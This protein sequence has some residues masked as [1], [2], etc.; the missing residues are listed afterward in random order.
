M[1]TVDTP[2]P[3]SDWLGASFSALVDRAK[4]TWLDLP[5]SA[6]FLS[7]GAESAC[8]IIHD[9]VGPTGPPVRPDAGELFIVDDRRISNWRDDGFEYE[10]RENTAARSGGAAA[11]IAYSD[12]TVYGART[13]DR[14]TLQHAAG[15]SIT[16]TFFAGGGTGGGDDE[17]EEQTLVIEWAL[18]VDGGAQ[19]RAL[20]LPRSGVGADGH[21]WLVQYLFDDAPPLYTPEGGPAG[22]AG[23]AD[24]LAA[25]DEGV[26]GADV[27]AEADTAND[28]VHVSFSTGDWTD[29]AAAS[30]DLGG[31]DGGENASIEESE[32]L[33]ALR[34]I[35]ETLDARSATSPPR[36]PAR[37]AQLTRTA[38]PI[39]ML[40]AASTLAAN[41]AAAARVAAASAASSPT[42]FTRSPESLREAADA[43]AAARR[44]AEAAAAL[45][46]RTLTSRRAA[47]L[48]MQSRRIALAS[49]LSADT[50]VASVSSASSSRPIESAAV[51]ERVIADV[52]VGGLQLPSTPSAPVD[53]PVPMPP[54]APAA[55]PHVVHTAPPISAASTVSSRPPLAPPQRNT[56]SEVGAAAARSASGSALPAPVRRSSIGSGRNANGDDDGRRIH[57]RRSGGRHSDGVRGDPPRR[58]R[59]RRDEPTAVRRAARRHGNRYSEISA[60]DDDVSDYTT[61]DSADGDFEYVGSRR[62]ASSGAYT[63][64]YSEEISEREGGG[65]R[66]GGG[67]E[68]KSGGG[69]RH[70]D[71]RSRRHHRSAHDRRSREHHAS[72]V[73]GPRSGAVSRQSSDLHESY[74]WGPPPAPAQSTWASSSLQAEAD[75]LLRSLV[76]APTAF[77][78][79]AS[80]ASLYSIPPASAPPA[81]VATAFGRPASASSLSS[82]AGAGSD[83]VGIGG[84]LVRALPLQQQQQPPPPPPSHMTSAHTAD[85]LAAIRALEME[86]ED[87]I[88]ADETAEIATANAAMFS[89]AP[90]EVAVSEMEEERISTV[91]ASVP[92]AAPLTLPLPPEIDEKLGAL[93]KG[94]R[95][96]ALLF[97]VPR[98]VGLCARVRD[99][100]SA[101]AGASGGVDDDAFTASLAAQLRAAKAEL[102]GALGLRGS[103]G[104]AGGGGLAELLRFLSTAS[105]ARARKGGN[106]ARA[107]LLPPR[108]RQG[109]K[110]VP[111]ARGLARAAARHASLKGGSLG[112][113]VADAAR[114]AA[115][116]LALASAQATSTSGVGS[117]S[118]AIGVS[119]AASLPSVSFSA[120][121]VVSAP[122]PTTTAA[123]SPPRPR[124]TTTSGTAAT[125]AGSTGLNENGDGVED[126]VFPGERDDADSAPQLLD[127]AASDAAAES[128]LAALE[129]SGSFRVFAFVSAARSL[130]PG[131]FVAATAA[132]TTATS[133]TRAAGAPHAA[134][135][136]DSY[137]SAFVTHR[138]SRDGARKVVGARVSSGVSARTLAP[139]YDT[140]MLLP[141]PPLAG[142][143]TRLAMADMALDATAAAAL[144]PSW[145]AGNVGGL[146][147]AAGGAGW[148]AVV[149]VLDADRFAKETFLGEL[150]LPLAIL[151]VITLGG[152]PG[153]RGALPPAEWRTLSFPPGHAF[154]GSRAALRI[155]VA[156]VAPDHATRC[157][158]I[159]RIL[160]SPPT[161]AA[162][163]AASAP[164]LVRP[165]GAKP[166]ASAPPSVTAVTPAPTP[167]SPP[168]P[169][170]TSLRGGAE[171]GGVP[172]T[173]LGAGGAPAR[174]ASAMTRAPPQR[175]PP[176]VPSPTP[177]PS[178]A[179]HTPPFPAI[180]ASDGRAGTRIPVPARVVGAATS[181]ATSALAR[182]TNAPAAPQPSSV[183]AVPSSIR[184]PSRYPA[185]SAPLSLSPAS[186]AEVDASILRFFGAQVGQQPQLPAQTNWPRSSLASAVPAPAPASTTMQ[187]P[188][189][190]A[191]AEAAAALQRFESR[192]LRAGRSS[193]VG[194]GTAATTTAQPPAESTGA[195]GKYVDA[196]R[197]AQEQADAAMA[198]LDALRL[199]RPT[200]AQY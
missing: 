113:G 4:E 101:L 131:A 79:F 158:T 155:R 15:E 143:P 21:I 134:P 77:D 125:L 6:E 29:V 76:M 150:V 170:S 149:T 58:H 185:P 55:V 70:H 196:A 163:A 92:L 14:D 110:T 138:A 144:A 91:A 157:T 18:A 189:A 156:L 73:E 103:G 74:I 179:S 123:F 136:R 2:D 105:A 86:E 40:A 89:V 129:A 146:G 10:T 181:A 94:W 19:R 122:P 177:T 167:A 160:S 53:A 112:R 17:T 67:R 171:K 135:P 23:E 126:V 30:V 97:R 16:V 194:A 118:G 69:R 66:G 192:M 108:A 166:L 51:A 34:R 11:G 140:P 109:G 124:T 80:H 198:R 78:P 98:V 200:G 165:R 32:I 116:K 42:S 197:R 182:G 87:A 27:T 176:P 64:D 90:A 107:P 99:T 54:P 132:A 186:A 173:S 28:D 59:H 117:G 57:W 142:L 102:A 162:V 183:S 9:A 121:A 151:P 145:G 31:D 120:S 83:A 36:S 22:A 184:A 50:S 154:A 49:R 128:A 153:R 5:S 178:Q 199:P 47:S 65:R 56:E 172:R 24:D 37:A 33:A 100:S 60:S 52:M 174:A 88:A 104:E 141:L 127:E 93:V 20:R 44:E 35:D 164:P 61:G 26:R 45:A 190:A 3:D 115:R 13:G 191:A 46:E 159:A 133:P 193:S 63:D 81:P 7:R 188:A 148:D 96:R 72:A 68:D 139:V 75:A 84:T 85:E 114:D 187:T 95:T 168:A 111:D 25:D 175:A 195:F 1:S 130:P 106:N 8:R 62:R 137:A 48:A 180:G 43:A 12:G 38:S 152:A 161:M 119:T 147:V 39:G 41:A 169:V 71:S 82:R